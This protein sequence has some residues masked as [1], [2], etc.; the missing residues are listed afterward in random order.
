MSFLVDTDTCSAYIKQRGSVFNRFLQYQG[1][2]QVSV[3]SLGELY[4]WAYRQTAPT[5]R[6]R[7]VLNL[8]NDVTLLDVD[9]D[10][11]RKY[12]EV[13]AYL[14]DIGR[15]MESD[16]LLIAATALVYGL[17]LVTHNTSDFVHVP[18][19]VVADWLIP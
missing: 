6:L 11:A 14:L 10:I 9:H 17:T 7:D 4:T 2:I 3:V 8:V 5:R 13:R 15:P 1:R 16:D 18:G 12:G 19:L